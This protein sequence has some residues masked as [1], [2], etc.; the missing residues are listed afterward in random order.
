MATKSALITGGNRGIGFEVCRQLAKR[1]HRVWLGARDVVQGSAAAARLRAERLEVTPIALDITRPDHI[2]AA[3]R[4]IEGES[5]SLD[6]LVNNAAILVAEDASLLAVSADDLH[7][8]FDTNLFAQIAVCQAF[9]PQMVRRRFGRVVNISSQAGQ[10]STMG[11]YAPAYAISKAALNAMTKSLA[12]TTH[13]TGVLVNCV[14]PGWVRTDMGGPHAPRSVEQGAETI[15]WA[16]TLPAD[17]P[18]GQFFTDKRPM[19]W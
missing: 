11:N 10:L 13:G 16:A 7:T 5:G 4:Q 3:R 14:N 6:V 2:A 18:S 15:V 1:G 8:T 17:G 9:V 19:A 12:A